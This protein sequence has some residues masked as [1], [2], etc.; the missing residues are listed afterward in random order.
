[1]NIHPIFVH[2]PIALLTIYGFL[3]L[4]R[5]KKLL[6]KPWF[7]YVKGSFVIIGALTSS[8]A[9]S[10]GELAEKAYKGNEI[11]I[12]IEAHA[13]W[14]NFASGIFA[15]LAFVY[16]LQLFSHTSY[17]EKIQNSFLSTIFNFIFSISSALYSSAW[18][19]MTA[20]FVGIV[21]IT[22]TGGL[23]GAIV[24]GQDVDPVVKIIYTLLIR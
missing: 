8:L 11:R 16:A 5:F 14:A 2:F 15:V 6:N 17:Y 1:M 21:A 4:L 13:K 19:M 12:L 3:E 24:Y 23:G 20:S 22:I 10:T 9:L 7:E 18:F